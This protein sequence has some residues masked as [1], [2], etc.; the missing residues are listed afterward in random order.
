MCFS[1]YTITVKSGTWYYIKGGSFRDSEGQP[2]GTLSGVTLNIEGGT[3]TSQKTGA[4]D[5][6]V[7]SPTGFDALLG[8][9]TLSISGG[10]FKGASI[11]GIAAR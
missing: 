2:V 10:T 9:A 4:D 5:N 7:I 6:A 3:F 1:D 11:V 8:D